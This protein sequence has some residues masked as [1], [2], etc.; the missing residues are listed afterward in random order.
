MFVEA[1]E[2]ASG[3]RHAVAR[4]LDVDRRYVTRMAKN[5]CTLAA[6]TLRCN[7]REGG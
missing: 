2:R 6:P 1:L 4:L 3:N 5:G 7:D